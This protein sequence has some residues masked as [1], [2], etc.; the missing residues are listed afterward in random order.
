MKNQFSNSSSI[1]A[2]LK[3]VEQL[4]S[5]N[6]LQDAAKHLNLLAKT[7]PQDPRVFLLG[8]RLA[9][10]AHNPQG[11]LQ[12]AIKAYQLAPQWPAAS[13]FLADVLADRGQSAEAMT[14]ATQAVQQATTQKTLAHELLVKA[15]EI[16]RRL[17]AYPQ[18]LAWLR[19]AKLIQP[20]DTAID[21]KIGL[22]LSASGDFADAIGIFTDLLSQLP[23]NPVLLIARRQAA[24]GAQN[25]PLA[26]QDGETLLAQDPANEEHQF[27]LA[28]ARGET[29]ET[30]P[31]S[32]V[33]S[34]FN[35]LAN[36]YD[37][38][39]AANPHNT[40]AQ[41]VAQRIHGWYP[42]DDAQVLDLGCGTGALG[43]ALGRVKGVV[44]GVDLA[45]HMLGLAA[46]HRLY[47]KLH[48]VNL[49]DALRDT[50]ADQYH[51]IAALN[52]FAYVGN[53]ATVAPNALRILLPGGHFIFNCEAG[54]SDDSASY[55]LH[56]NL[57]YTHQR[58]YVQQLLEY[59]GFKDIDLQ[60]RV[61]LHETGQ[62]VTG[63]L[64]SAVK[65]LPAAEKAKP[66]KRSAAKK[67]QE[68]QVFLG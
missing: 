30:Q 16:A 34:H 57:R 25:I 65:P 14:L 58:A 61:L 55:R 9:E 36:L 4:I 13:V 11:T 41:E 47:D 49:L 68:N 8:A 42:N 40:L 46:R 60:D 17:G 27:Y 1:V 23:G 59:A 43:I 6:E 50:L 20:A 3:H 33:A 38:Q 54:T 29:P 45:D 12:S 62:P 31:A 64:V 67:Q 24:L 53:L 15:A 51:V 32:A 19:Q 28:I 21:Y 39:Q 44:V 10:A 48:A 56:T 22:S 26:A 7:S 35:S 66:R 5:H 37:A 63:F 18:A 2:R 52:V